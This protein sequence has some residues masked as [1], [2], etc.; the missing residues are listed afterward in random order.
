MLIFAKPDLRQSAI[1]SGYS[2]RSLADGAGIAKESV[3]RLVHG[4]PVR[5]GTAKK[6]C[7][8][9]GQEFDALFEIRE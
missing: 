7:E 5:A 2:L 9:L 6:I 4:R 8:V 1:K 3:T